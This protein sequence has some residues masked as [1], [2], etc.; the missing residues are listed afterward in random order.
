MTVYYEGGLKDGRADGGD[1][2]MEFWWWSVFVHMFLLKP[3]LPL[4]LHKTDLE[5][6]LQRGESPL[7][8]NEQHSVDVKVQCGE[9]LR[10]WGTAIRL[11][12]NTFIGL[13][14]S[15]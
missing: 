12:I 6:T 3:G 10:V 11:V 2:G 15:N 5:W 4:H 7:Q 14:L 1:R 13:I 9:G 8:L